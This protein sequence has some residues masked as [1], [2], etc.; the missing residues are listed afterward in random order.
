MDM[1]KVMD[2]AKQANIHAL[3]ASLPMVSQRLFFSYCSFNEGPAFLYATSSSKDGPFF[4]QSQ[5]SYETF[6][7]Q[8][9]DTSVGGRGCQLSG[10][11][12]QRVAIARALYNSPSLLLLDE[13]TSALDSESERVIPLRLL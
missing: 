5:R 1:D 7:C 13:A 12:R 9:Y 11:Q 4:T 3:I 10:G 2:A 8:G 6:S